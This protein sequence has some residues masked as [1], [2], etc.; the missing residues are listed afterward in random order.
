MLIQNHTL[1]AFVIYC[2]LLIFL[3]IFC[4]LEVKII[5]IHENTYLPF[6]NYYLVY[7]KAEKTLVPRGTKRLGP[8]FRPTD[9]FIHHVWGE[10][11]VL[12]LHWVTL[13]IKT[14]RFSILQDD[15]TCDFVM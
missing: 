5:P 15:N 1:C 14:R 7:L 8:T 6:M 3:N 4:P 9:W 10:Y 11:A 12:G 13:A 2:I